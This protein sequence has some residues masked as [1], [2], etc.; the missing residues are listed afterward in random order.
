[1][2]D[3]LIQENTGDLYECGMRYTSYHCYADTIC[4]DGDYHWKELLE[5]AQYMK[6]L[7]NKE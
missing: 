6:E 5:I 7:Q 4:L 3:N 1:M 2:I